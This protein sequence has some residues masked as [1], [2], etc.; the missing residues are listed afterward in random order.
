LAEVWNGSSWALMNTNV[1]LLSR[2][3]AFA[4]VSCSSSTFCVAVGSKPST[5]NAIVPEAA[6]WGT[7]P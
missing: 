6:F 1:L 4:S 5:N 7:L 2:A 3:Y